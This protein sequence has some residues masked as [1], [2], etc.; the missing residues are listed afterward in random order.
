MCNFMDKSTLKGIKLEPKRGQ[1]KDK[2]G[3]KMNRK[4]GTIRKKKKKR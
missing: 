3:E 2:K 1:K 4:E